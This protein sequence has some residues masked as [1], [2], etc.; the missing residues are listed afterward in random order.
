MPE[1]VILNAL[2][3]TLARETSRFYYQG[4]PHVSV[5]LFIRA[6]PKELT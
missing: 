6:Y 1:F 4:K 3:P 2:Y 5:Y